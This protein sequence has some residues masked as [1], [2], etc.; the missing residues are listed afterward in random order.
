MR[1][2]MTKI[3]LITGASRGLGFATAKRLGG[4]DHHIIAVARTVGGLEELDDAIRAK[5]G[6]STL[7]PFDI[8]D[9][10]GLQTLG[11]SVFDRWGRLD[12][13]IHCAAHAAP[14]SPIGHIAPKDLDRAWAVNARATQ[15]LI[16]MLDP[17]LKAAPDGQAIYCD[18]RN[19]DAKFSGAYRTSKLAALNFIESWIAE[20][21]Q[22]G[23]KISIFEP[24]PMPTA[25]RARFFPGEDRDRLS[26][27]EKEAERL[28]SLLL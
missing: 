7:V 18:D 10:T 2:F 13:F 4:P 22:T 3:S 24:K 26:S 5:G 11:K 12:T 28:V 8:T 17:L 6:Q 19:L 15:R 25:L 16:T 20:S 14:L 23:P 9:E 27:I 21:V 1:S